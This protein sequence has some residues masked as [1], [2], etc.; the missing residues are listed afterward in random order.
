MEKAVK[1]WGAKRDRAIVQCF[2]CGKARCIYTV[3]D[4]GHSIVMLALQQKMESLSHHFSCGDLLFD[5]SH[6]LSKL[7]LKRK[8][9][10]CESLI[11][12]GC[13]NN[14]DRRLKLT[15]LALLAYI[16]AIDLQE[17][18]D[19]AVRQNIAKDSSWVRDWVKA[20]VITC[21]LGFRREFD[22]RRGF[23]IRFDL[24]GHRGSFFPRFFYRAQ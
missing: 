5:D 10:T 18:E 13:Y 11:E 20:F 24:R 9:L 23:A 22:P 21:A 4:D 1:G 2:H 14:K 8:N 17:L 6:Y 3:T 19:V 16:Y 12:K 15:G 7:V